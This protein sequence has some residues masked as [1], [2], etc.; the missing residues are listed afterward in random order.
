MGNGK[1]ASE[2]AEEG[3]N[4]IMQYYPNN[5]S[6]LL[7]FL[8]FLWPYH[9]PDPALL[10]QIIIPIRP[11]TSRTIAPAV[12]RFYVVKVKLEVRPHMHRLH[13]VRFPSCVST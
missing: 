2:I 13:M 10:P 8:D 3:F 12:G 11:I 4:L 7:N 9:L 5:K 1:S 6:I